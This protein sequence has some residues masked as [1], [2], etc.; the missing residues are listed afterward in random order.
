M[1]RYIRDAVH[2]GVG[3]GVRTIYLS[4][5]HM[6]RASNNSG[7]QRSEEQANATQV[8]AMCDG[9][10]CLPHHWGTPKIRHCCKD[11]SHF[12]AQRYVSIGADV[13]C[14]WLVGW[15]VGW[16]VAPKKVYNWSR[17]LT[18]PPATPGLAMLLV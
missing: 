7:C 18:L 8:E 13:L 6:V 3:W 1:C 15:L 10:S 16:L 2:A 12:V 14:F 17:S 5:F 11:P 4:T 9:D